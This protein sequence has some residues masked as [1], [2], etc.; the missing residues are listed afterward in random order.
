MIPQELPADDK[1]SAKLLSPSAV[2]L[3]HDIFKADKLV[4][5][6]MHLEKS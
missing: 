5:D 2:I 3:L 6:G 1:A 4:R